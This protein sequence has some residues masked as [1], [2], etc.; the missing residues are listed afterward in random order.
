[1]EIQYAPNFARAY[2]KLPAEVRARAKDAEQVFRLDPFDVRLKTHKLHG[3]LS[4]A[5]AF[6][7]DARHRI[8]FEFCR[9]HVVRFLAIGGHHVY[10]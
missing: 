1:M 8:I 6:S 7:V 5:W 10:Q 9:K 2:R 4:D 3:R